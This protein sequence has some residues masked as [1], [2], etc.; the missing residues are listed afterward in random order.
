MEQLKLKTRQ[1][2]SQFFY[3]GLNTYKS[4]NV[5]V[6]SKRLGSFLKLLKKKDLMKTKIVCTVGP[7]CKL[8]E[9]LREMALAGMDAA[10]LNFSHGTHHE[11]AQTIIKIRKISEELGKPIA[12]IQDLPGPKIRIGKLAYNSVELKEGNLFT[13][14]IREVEGNSEE[15]SINLDH[16]PKKIRRGD[17]VFLADGFVRLVVTDVSGTDIDCKVL[18]GGKITSGKGVNFPGLTLDIETISEEDQ[19][20]L[21]FG[22]KHGVDF[23][24]FSFLMRDKDVV[25]ARNLISAYG[26]EASLI[27]K[28]EK[29]EALANIDKIIK[30]TDGIMIARGDLG[31]EI[32]IEKVAKVQ[33]EIIGKCNLSGKPVITATQMLMSMVN[34]PLPTRAEVT[35]VAN[36]IIDGTDAVMLSEET[37]VGKY[38]VGSVKTLVKIAK[39]TE[40]NLPYGQILESRASA[41]RVTLE[42]SLSFA[43]VRIAMDTNSVSIIAPSRSGLTARRISRYRPP[44]PIIAL[45]PSLKTAKELTLAWGVF[46]VM[47]KILRNVDSMFKEAADTLVNLGLAEK[48]DNIV[49]VAGD[50]REPPGTTELIKVQRLR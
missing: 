11:H 43:A 46:P 21:S 26:G 32:P 42:D 45:T 9:I 4:E 7:A 35:D 36:A 22:L 37:A 25:D 48:K 8:T 14:T 31:V 28:I 41:L 18:V 27:V 2:L 15:V 30:L 16:I 39:V 24:A 17:T 49:I 29:R 50:P 44:F 3:N 6:M 40:A 38:P 20:H 33:K 1:I 12:I 10:R 19:R 5:V 34:Y 13:L 47:T 23:V